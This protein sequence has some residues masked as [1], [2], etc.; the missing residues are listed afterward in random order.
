M[1]LEFSLQ[2]FE[3]YVSN[4]MKNCSV[5]TELLMRTDGRTER[6]DE[7]DSRF[8]QFSDAPDKNHILRVRSAM[9]RGGVTGWWSIGCN[10][11]FITRTL[12]LRLLVNQLEGNMLDW[13]GSYVEN[14][15]TFVQSF[16]YKQISREEAVSDT[17]E[18]SR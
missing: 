11:I 2:I 10:D 7:A 4:F 3:K 14:N 17:S 1:K 15:V 8:S 18:A 5:W 13:T 12:C 16:V 6:H 9:K